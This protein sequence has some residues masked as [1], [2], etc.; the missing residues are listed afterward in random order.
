MFAREMQ[1]R[2]ILHLVGKMKK[3]EKEQT[4]RKELGV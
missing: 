2:Q 3:K 4:G 1:M